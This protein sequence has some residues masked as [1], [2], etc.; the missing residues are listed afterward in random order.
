[1]KYCWIILIFLYS[2]IASAVP[3]RVDYDKSL[4]RF[5]GVHAGNEFEGVFNEWTADIDFDH[6]DPSTAHAQIII[7][8][9]SAKTGNKLY[10]GTLPN[11]D[12]LN[13]ARFPQAIFMSDKITKT[14]NGYRV[15]GHLTLRGIS[16]PVSFEF[17]L[18]GD[19]P[20]AMT[21]Y[22]P[23]NRLD[24]NIG[25]DSDPN[26]EWVSDIINITLQLLAVKK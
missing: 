24:Y 23:I 6:D 7:N 20:V 4:I 25:K 11:E 14:D 10:D 1:M 15:E 17:N 16:H 26:A 18:E 2:S 12:W 8:T 13:T 9:A 22:I 3:Y 19:D 5:S 21:A